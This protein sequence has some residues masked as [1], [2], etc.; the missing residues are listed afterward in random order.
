MRRGKGTTGLLPQ[1][2]SPC[3]T[4]L[5]TATFGDAGGGGTWKSG[6]VTQ[7]RPL[8]TPRRA[9]ETSK[10]PPPSA[11]WPLRG[12]GPA[13]DRTTSSRLPASRGNQSQRS[14]SASTTSYPPQIL[15]SLG[16]VLHTVKH[17]CCP[18]GRQLTFWSLSNWTC[19]SGLFEKKQKKQII[20]NWTFLLS[21]VKP[22][23]L[24]RL[25]EENSTEGISLNLKV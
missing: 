10:W 9:T 8:F 13:P 1:V 22:G 4:C 25:K 20:K 18:Q 12:R 14:S 7:E 2:V 6:S 11:A 23:P 16:S 17:E 24:R 19:T 21:T 3:S 5:K 15:L